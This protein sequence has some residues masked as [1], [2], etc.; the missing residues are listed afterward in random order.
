MI[1][2]VSIRDRLHK[3]FQRAFYGSKTHNIYIKDGNGFTINQAANLI[4]G[5][6]VFRTDLLNINGQ[7]YKAWITL[8]LN[9]PKDGYGNFRSKMFSE[10]YGFNLNEVLSRYSIKELEDPGLMEK[11]ETSLKNG[12]SPLVTVNKNGEDIRLR[13]AAVPQFTQINF[14]E[15]NGKPVMREQFLTSKAQEKLAHKTEGHQQGMSKSQGLS[16]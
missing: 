9:Q 12:G 15:Q 8:E 1:F 16:R 13:I 10:G 7:E 3:D 6:S 2:Q 11:L 14:Y 5:R 4:Q